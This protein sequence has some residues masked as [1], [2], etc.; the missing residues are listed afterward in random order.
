MRLTF[1]LRRLVARGPSPAADPSTTQRVTDLA[2]GVWQLQSP[3]WQTNSV[4]AVADG[5]AL[6]C[7]PAFTPAEIDA[8]GAEAARLGGTPAH[9]LLTHADFDH[10]CGI[11]AFPDVEVIAGTE[12]AR[13][14]E[15]G[16]AA[17]ELRA[18][19]QEWGADWTLDG[20]RVE[21][22]VEPGAELACGPFRVAVVDAPSH[23]REGVGYVLLEQGVLLPGDHLSAITYPLLAGSLERAT[24]A[25]RRLLEA[26]ETHTPRWVVPGHGPALSLAEAQEVGE[27]DLAYLERLA[28]AA[29]DARSAGLPPGRA[30]LQVYAVEPPRA[31]TDDFEL[32]GIRAGNV[33]LALA[34]DDV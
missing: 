26:L 24:Q 16:A 20:L 33:R 6:L 19:G 13:K 34:E 28:A 5:E 4:L 10:T 23:G 8:I 1:I 11:G 31:N 3:L 18:A 25:C 7:D 9:L 29:R 32:Y 30:L 22:V 2:E 14:V 12:T 17:E 15:S 27:S 21:C